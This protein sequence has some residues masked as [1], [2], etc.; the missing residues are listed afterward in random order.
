MINI[1]A[2]NKAFPTPIS[3][4]IEP[5]YSDELREIWQQNDRDWSVFSKKVMEVSF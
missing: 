1:E 4:K 2:Q 3:E 5:Y